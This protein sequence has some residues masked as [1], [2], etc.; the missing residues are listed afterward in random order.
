MPPQKFAINPESLQ[1]NGWGAGSPNQRFQ[2]APMAGMSPA[3]VPH[4]K[5]KWAFG[6]DGAATAYSQPT[7]LGGT[8]FIGSEQGQIYSLNARS[9]CINWTFQ[10]AAGVRTAIVAGRE[11]ETNSSSV[12]IYFG[13]QH[14]AVYALDPVSGH[15]LWKIQTHSHATTMITGSPQIWK[16]RLYVP[17]ASSEEDLAPNPHYE[18]CTFRGSLIAM[19]ASS[20]KQIW[21]TFTF[22][23]VPQKT[24]LNSAGTQLWGPSG[25]GVWSTPTLDP[26]H[27]MIY[28]ATGN[29]Y[30]DP[31]P[32]TSDAILA[33]DL[34]IGKILWSRQLTEND[35]YN[36]ACFQADQSNCPKSRGKDFDFGSSPILV[37]LP[38]GRRALI[39][40]Q[41]SGVVYALDPDHEGKTLWQMRLGDGGPLGGIE[42]GAAAD[43]DTQILYAALSDCN[44]KPIEWMEAGAKK[45]GF[46]LDPA[47]GGGM[48]ALHL[49][50]GHQVWHTS[51]P[52]NACENHAMCSPA[53]LAAV[54]AI[55]G[56]VFS[57]ALDGHLR[58]Y[59]ADDGRILWDF[60]TVQ[61]FATV[62]GVAA[63]GGSLNGPGPTIVGGMLYV[64]SGY[65]R[66]GEAAG[67]VLLAFSVDGK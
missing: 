57:G 3:E 49:A 30:S 4:L 66:F 58:A 16:G 8:V 26:D 1:W 67:N 47:K 27:N 35:A 25:V 50:D 9:G 6:F 10:A 28:I 23:E 65:G 22:S 42:W 36:S 46:G 37:G 32:A 45:S 14:G 43:T 11:S 39:A 55:P 48:F 38:G 18:C 29:A 60:D 2:S 19:D 51:P 12:A 21:K 52:A 56:A 34:A 20:G 61:D 64:D 5:L 33:L 54:S 59:S 63:R 53:Q 24:Q 13:D 15:M 7:V 31:A 40:P 62:N 44:W 17:V 41:K